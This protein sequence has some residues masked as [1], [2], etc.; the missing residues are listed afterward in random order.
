MLYSPLFRF[1]GF[2]LSII[3]CF[4]N[5][6]CEYVLIRDMTCI[7]RLLLFFSSFF[8][9]FLSKI[10]KGFVLL[11]NVSFKNNKR[12]ATLF[13]PN[14]HNEESILILRKKSSSLHLIKSY[15][16]AL[17]FLST[18]LITF[19]FF[20]LNFLQFSSSNLFQ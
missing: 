10:I 18:S 12:P 16:N 7:L 20:P 13:S 19:L 14:F 6:H 8:F 15:A 9:S 11:T 2:L 17:A 3:Y 5:R 1:L 4:Y